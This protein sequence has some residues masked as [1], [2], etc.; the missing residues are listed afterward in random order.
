MKKEKQRKKSIYLHK[1]YFWHTF[2][3]LTFFL[4]KAIN[5]AL[6]FIS[7]FGIANTRDNLMDFMMRFLFR[8]GIEFAYYFL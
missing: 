3:L 5:D 2:L 6:I 8:G 7:N 1:K 4:E